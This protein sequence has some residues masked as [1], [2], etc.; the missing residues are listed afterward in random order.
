MNG[1]DQFYTG[2]DVAESCFLTAKHVME[3]AGVAAPF[4]IEPS[5]GDGAFFDLMP[6][7][8]RVGI[9]LAPRRDNVISGDF[10]AWRP[11][12]D[13]PPSQRM[14]LGNPPFGKRGALAIQFF[15]HAATLSDTIGFILPVSF[16]KFG[17]Q[18]ALA[19]D[20]RLVVQEPLGR[21]SFHTLCGKPYSVNTEFQVWT[22]LDVPLEDR[23]RRARPK[24]THKDFALRQYNNTEAA[25]KVF[26]ERFALAVPCQGW[27]NY[28]RREVDAKR[29][30]KN[31]QWMLFDAP[32]PIINRINNFDFREL[33]YNCSTSVPGFRMGDF[34]EAYSNVY[35]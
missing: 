34:V 1:L 35:G 18:H 30:E 14:T 13:A 20:M 5:A 33:A 3:Q 29:C 28:E 23:R 27:Q 9:D 26:R 32:P 12:M 25:L 16:R 24:T 11:E 10:L 2:R 4:L 21:D 15:N 17:A 19:S 31:K 22:R 8:R 7:D 6:P